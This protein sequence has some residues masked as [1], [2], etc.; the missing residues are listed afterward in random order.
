MGTGQQM[1]GIIISY[2]YLTFLANE[3]NSGKCLASVSFLMF[4]F[5][6][7]PLPQ[8]LSTSILP[9]PQILL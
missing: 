7:D 4:L 2:L 5:A 9:V 8:S 3:N 1:I 6:W